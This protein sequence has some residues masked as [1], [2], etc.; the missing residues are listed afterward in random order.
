[1]FG[2]VT[3]LV[4]SWAVL[5]AVAELFESGDP[6]SDMPSMVGWGTFTVEHL[7]FGLVLGV[8]VMGA[9][10]REHTVA[11]SVTETWRTDDDRHRAA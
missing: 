3:V 7:I 1:V 10:P 2:I 8:T 11:T 9:W 4:M 6:I 5:P